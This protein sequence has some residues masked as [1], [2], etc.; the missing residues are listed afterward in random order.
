MDELNKRECENLINKGMKFYDDVKDL[1]MPYFTALIGC[2]VD[3]YERDHEEFD[4]NYF[5][6]FLL[7]VRPIV[8]EAMGDDF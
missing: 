8:H 2:L 3:F 6:Q 1:S 7:D 4:G 5:L